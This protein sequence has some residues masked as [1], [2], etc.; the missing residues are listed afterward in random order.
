M[1]D[2][3]EKQTEYVCGLAGGNSTLEIARNSSVSHH[4]V[5]NT[6][7]NARVRMDCPN[8][9]NLVAT[10]ISDGLI[11]KNGKGFVPNEI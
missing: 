11:V 10:A 1:R 5:R 4:T 2:L 7:R 8:S 9:V 3:T 6:L